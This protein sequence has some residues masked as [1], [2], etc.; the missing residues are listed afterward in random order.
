MD[1][2]K[3]KRL[4][5]RELNPDTANYSVSDNE[6]GLLGPIERVNIFIGATNCGKSRLL[7]ALAKSEKFTFPDM[8]QIGAL[9]KAKEQ[10]SAF[11]VDSRGLAAMTLYNGRAQEQNA[12]ELM[13][14]VN[15]HRDTFIDSQFRR[16]EAKDTQSELSLQIRT[17]LKADQAF[18]VMIQQY[19]KTV[20]ETATKAKSEAVPNAESS[21]FP[22][23]AV[24]SWIRI[25]RA[26]W[27]CDG[28]SSTGYDFPYGRPMPRTLAIEHDILKDVRPQLEPLVRDFEQFEK[29]VPHEI[30]EP[31]HIYIPVLRTAMS[32]RDKENKRIEDV[33]D[34]AIRENY[35]LPKSSL[36]VSTG[37]TLYQELIDAREHF[38]FVEKQYEDFERFLSVHFFDNQIVRIRPIGLAADPNQHIQLQVA[39]RQARYL[40]QVGDGLQALI[41]LTYQLFM[42]EEGSWIFIEEPELY[43]HPGLQRIFLETLLRNED[44]KKKN[45]TVF[46]TT[47]SNHLLR[48]ALPE[49]RVCRLKLGALRVRR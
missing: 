45:L 40:H 4:I 28:K 13:N 18:I 5:L 26:Y 29:N 37:L 7:R 9:E 33:F 20:L 48:I 43:L 36:K 46:F 16:E 30:V 8:A 14:L 3:E 6:F 44:L 22:F 24:M 17:H 21:I 42:A 31:K 39:G 10:W 27:D 1:D 41:M 49:Y 35:E 38:A 25:L 11:K 19:F 12:G 2:N 23:S 47:H 34:T 32:I 15:V